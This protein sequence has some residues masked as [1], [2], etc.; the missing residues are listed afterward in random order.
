MCV[1]DG[2]YRRHN[3]WSKVIVCTSYYH[4]YPRVTSVL[5]ETFEAVINSA[6]DSKVKIQ[7]GH[8]QTSLINKI[9]VV[10]FLSFLEHNFGI[11][12]SW[13]IISAAFQPL[14]LLW[15]WEICEMCMRSSEKTR[16]HSS[17]SHPVL[18][19]HRS[20]AAP[21]SVQERSRG[22]FTE[23]NPNITTVFQYLCAWYPAL[24]S[25][26]LLLCSTPAVQ[27]KQH[28][29]R[30][31]R[32]THPCLAWTVQLSSSGTHR[33]KSEFLFRKTD[34]HHVASG[35]EVTA[36][37]FKRK[38]APGA[39]SLSQLILPFLKALMEAEISWSLRHKHYSQQSC[40]SEEF[41]PISYI[42]GG[43]GSCVL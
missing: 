39:P 4:R 5:Q 8:H 43:Q 32:Q 28:D 22:K 19:Q 35:V 40:S 37:H 41:I 1:R 3:A 20:G 11:P 9:D 17:M 6:W 10:F 42:F 38:L 2:S 12:Y 34:D 16:W 27:W 18:W 23:T 25:A 31:L 13:H 7:T 26:K 24:V 14:R 33:S 15:N 21:A 30:L 36:L 29:W